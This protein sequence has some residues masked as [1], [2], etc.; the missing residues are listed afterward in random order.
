VQGAELTSKKK[1]TLQ[2]K[3][4]VG[5]KGNKRDIN[6]AWGKKRSKLGPYQYKRD[7]TEVGIHGG[8]GGAVSGDDDDIGEPDSESGRDDGV[9]WMGQVI[10]IYPYVPLPLP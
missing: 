2:K 4:D 9:G 7:G 1:G 5:A 6:L 8:I 3:G 10:S